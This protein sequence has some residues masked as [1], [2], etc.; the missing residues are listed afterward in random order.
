MFRGIEN[1]AVERIETSQTVL[2]IPSEDPMTV[3]G[4]VPVC[5][6]PINFWGLGN[7][8]AAG[9]RGNEVGVRAIGQHA[10][11]CV[12]LERWRP[13]IGDRVFDAVIVAFA[14]GRRQAHHHSRGGFAALS[15]C[16]ARHTASVDTCLKRRR[17][18]LPG[19][20]SAGQLCLG[21]F[22]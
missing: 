9:I 19:P 15:I 1:G 2:P 21:T 3:V 4:H 8:E 17:V 12:R 10:D 7:E 6:I 13:L 22:R 11:I 14:V 5:I 16:T 20:T 18:S